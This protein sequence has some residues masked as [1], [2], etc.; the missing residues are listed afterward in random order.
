MSGGPGG[1]FEFDLL[2]PT[3]MSWLGD[4]SRQMQAP[5]KCNGGSHI[6]SRVCIIL[7]SL[8]RHQKA[9]AVMAA[10]RSLQVPR[11]VQHRLSERSR[12]PTVFLTLS[13]HVHIVLLGATKACAGDLCCDLCWGSSLKDLHLRAVR[14]SC[15]RSSPC[16]SDI[17]ECG[18]GFL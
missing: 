9:C 18:N 10:S 5:V 4:A 13:L 3:H 2:A 17:G 14:G 6:H 1:P 8:A 15:L 12:L 7:V 16:L 11:K